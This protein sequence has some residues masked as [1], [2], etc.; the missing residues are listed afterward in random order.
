MS[1]NKI[2][3]F[4]KRIVSSAEKWTTSNENGHAQRENNVIRI[5]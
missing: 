2:D 5:T 1:R 3:I 4:L